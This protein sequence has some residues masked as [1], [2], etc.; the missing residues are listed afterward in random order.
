MKS[1]KQPSMST[2]IIPTNEGVKVNGVRTMVQAISDSFVDNEPELKVHNGLLCGI[3]IAGQEFEPPDGL[4]IIAKCCT[5]HDFVVVPVPE[6]LFNLIRDA[7]TSMLLLA[8]NKNYE[9]YDLEKLIQFNDSPF[10]MVLDEEEFCKEII[11]AITL[12]AAKQSS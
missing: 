12:L 8:E 2:L 9:V 6:R 3:I 1:E 10:V 7:K 5:N 11:N 4:C